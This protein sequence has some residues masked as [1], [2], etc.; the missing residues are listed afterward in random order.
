MQENKVADTAYFCTFTYEVPPLT[1]NNMMTLRKPDFQNFIKRLRK[2]KRDY[3]SQK[4]KYY[5]CGEYGDKYERPHYHAIIFNSSPEDMSNT[6][7]SFSNLSDPE[8][9]ILGIS[10]YDVVNHQTCAY[11]AKYMNKGKL[12]PK[13]YEDL[14]TPEFQL[15]SKDLGINFLTPAVRAFYNQDPRR[16]SVSVDGFPK[17]LPRYFADKLKICPVFH[18]AKTYYAQDQ[19]AKKH[20]EQLLG[21][22][23]N[24]TFHQTFEAYR[25]TQKVAALQQFR[26]KQKQRKKLQ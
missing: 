14:R 21:W 10:T 3:S 25:Y 1:D 23:R 20:A 16:N 18:L 11:V 13:F 9:V 4:I 22:E 6:W 24:K 15:F 8:G 17:A 2:R 26:D 7:N 19:A 12:I 5:A